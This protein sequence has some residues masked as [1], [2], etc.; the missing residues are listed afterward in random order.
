MFK[1]SLGRVLLLL[2]SRVDPSQRN[3]A[4]TCG[5]LLT[6]IAVVIADRHKLMDGCCEVDSSR[7]C[8]EQEEWTAATRLM[9]RQDRATVVLLLLLRW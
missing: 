7:R 8:G 3:D 9:E 1:S 6:I 2:L 4:S 5:R